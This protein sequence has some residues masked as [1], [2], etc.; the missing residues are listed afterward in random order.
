[1]G[2]D[3]R[4]RLR[5]LMPGSPGRE[6]RDAKRNHHSSVHGDEASSLHHHEE[7]EEDHREAGTE[8]V[9]SGSAAAHHLPRNQVVWAWFPVCPKGCAERHEGKEA[10]AQGSDG[11]GSAE[12]AR[13]AIELK[14]CGGFRKL[15]FASGP[16]TWLSDARLAPEGR[17]RHA[18]P[19]SGV[20]DGCNDLFATG[21]QA[22]V[23]SRVAL[24]DTGLLYAIQGCSSTVEQRSP[25]PPVRVRFLP[26][27]PTSSCRLRTVNQSR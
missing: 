15:V 24:R 22:F 17:G 26:P 19:E 3:R 16:G 6:A 5:G 2:W 12:A 9:Q 14:G 18:L 20:L 13:D 7:Q 23:R 1:M 25:K 8:E 10:A 11:P 21:D 27:L 4:Q